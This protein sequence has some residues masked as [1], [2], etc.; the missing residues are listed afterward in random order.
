MAFEDWILA[1][2]R[3]SSKGHRRI[4]L[5]DKMAFFQ[6]LATLVSSGVPLVG[7]IELAARQT[8]S[9]RLRSILQ[10]VASRV[11]AG[12]SLQA[13][14][15]DYREVFEDHWIEVIGTG[16]VSGKMS[17]VL[18]ALNEQ[19]RESRETRRK[20]TGALIYPIIL[21]IVAVAVVALMLWFVVPTFANMFREMNASLPSVTQYVMG[22]SDFL[23]AYGIYIVVGVIALVV[24]ARQ[25]LRT[26]R[27]RRRVG[28]IGLAIPMVG[29]LVVQSAMYKFAL[30][31][32]LLLKSGVP[33]L[34]T[35]S[36]LSTVFRGNP[37]YR[38]A[39]LRVQSYVAAGQP[40][41]DSLEETGLFTSMMTNMVRV[42]E[43]SAQLTGVMDQIAPYYKER[44]QSFITRVTRLMEPAIIVVMGGTIAGLMLAIYMP[45]FEMAGAVK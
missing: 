15:G 21:L 29:D 34:E 19:I 7:A 28:A 9:T 2:A 45:M 44:V 13:V 33:M 37:L 1:H 32:A 10:E 11:A 43:E 14:L 5:D 4:T 22:A 38:D 25:C 31:L 20:V 12:G 27:G 40:L 35:L 26:E 36:A 24:A 8:Q 6:Q 18:C 3:V 23:V 41:A 39:L 16:E 30:N 17:A 42:G